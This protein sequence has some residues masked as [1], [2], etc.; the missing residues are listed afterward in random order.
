MRAKYP[1]YPDS[2]WDYSV[3]ESARQDLRNPNKAICIYCRKQAL[4]NDGIEHE[5][6]CP[7]GSG[8]MPW[9]GWST[10]CGSVM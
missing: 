7:A 8:R 4:T 5:P 1:P 9:T 3:V 6:D 2:N 10:E